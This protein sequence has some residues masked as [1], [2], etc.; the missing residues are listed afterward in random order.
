[1]Y[2]NVM[3]NGDWKGCYLLIENVA[4]GANKVDISDDGYLIENDAYYWAADG[5][6][7]K[8][9]EQNKLLGYTFKYPEITDISDSKVITIQNYMQNI[10]DLLI[11]EDSSV[12]DYLDIDSFAEWILIKD[13]LGHTDA[14]GSNIYM[15]IDSLPESGLTDSKLKCGPQWDFDGA[16]YYREGWSDQRYWDGC[17]ATYLFNFPEFREAYKNKFYEVK[18]S[19]YVDGPA[20]IEGIYEEY[21]DDLWP[22]QD[23][24]DARWQTVAEQLDKEILVKSTLLTRRLDWMDSVMEENLA[25]FE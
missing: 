2:V 25:S 24:D 20:F 10:E 18:D 11:A 6:Y 21:G 3:M 7:F 16:F 23:L 1:M 13:I 15:Y 22:S 17:F 5:L 14:A 4:A 8:T 19:L 9:A 12:F